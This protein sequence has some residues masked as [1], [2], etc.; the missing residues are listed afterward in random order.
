MDC[1]PRSVPGALDAV[2][3]AMGDGAVVNVHVQPRSGRPGIAGRHG[4]ALRIRV[5]APPVD[6]RAND[7]VVRLLAGALEVDARAVTLVSGATSRVKRVHVAGLDVARAK[8]QLARVLE[9][10]GA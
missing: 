1:P 10:G 5:K 9:R 4:D 8:D 7:E 6:G 2:I 3:S